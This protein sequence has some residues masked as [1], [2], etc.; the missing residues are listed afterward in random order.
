MPWFLQQRQAVGSCEY[1]RTREESRL[2][3]EWATRSHCTPSNRKRPRFAGAEGR[4]VDGD[5]HG[6]R[7]Q[8]GCS[9][10]NQNCTGAGESMVLA[11]SKRN[12]AR[13]R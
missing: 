13:S 8:K 3:P 5:T 9:T 4:E 10:P 12:M 7:S 6:E 1:Y 2:L 11:T